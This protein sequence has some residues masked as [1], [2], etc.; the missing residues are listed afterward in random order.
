MKQMI[1]ATLIVGVASIG[2]IGCGDASKSSVKQETKIASPTG[3]TTISTERDV[4]TTGDK[5]PAATH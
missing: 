1:A 5:P 2:V 3:T 4:K